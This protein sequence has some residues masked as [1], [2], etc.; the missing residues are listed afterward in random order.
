MPAVDAVCAKHVFLCALETYQKNNHYHYR[1]RCSRLSARWGEIAV[2]LSGFWSD[3]SHDGR[4]PLEPTQGT[5]VVCR[6][7]TTDFS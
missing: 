7:H 3:E 1:R 6:N 4:S 2:F 5:A